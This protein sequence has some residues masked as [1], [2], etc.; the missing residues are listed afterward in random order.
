MPETYEAGE[1]YYAPPGHVP[2]VEAG[3]ETIE[4]SPTTEYR[5]TQEVLGRNLA[6]AGI[7]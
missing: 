4:F 6:A 3:T 7:I 5:Q 1:A 2:V